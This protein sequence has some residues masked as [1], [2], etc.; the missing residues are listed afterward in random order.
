MPVRLA[1]A[2]ARPEIVA[3]NDKR[4]FLFVA[5]LVNGRDAALLS[6]RRI[7]QHHLVFTVFAGERVL[8]YHRD[9]CCIAADT[10]KDEIHTTESRDA[11]DQLDAAKLLGV[12]IGE[13]FLIQLVVIANE[14]VSD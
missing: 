1:L 3:M 11:I 8:Y 12:Q 10:V 13:L 5:D 9:V 6:E 7:R 2:R 4:L 14:I